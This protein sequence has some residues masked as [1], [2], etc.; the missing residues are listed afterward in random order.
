MLLHKDESLK[1]VPLDWII[2]SLI[3]D[4]LTIEWNDSTWNSIQTILQ[5]TDHP[6]FFC[7]WQMEKKINQF[8]H[9]EFWD[10]LLSGL[11]TC[12]P[13]DTRVTSGPRFC[14]EPNLLRPLI[15][16]ILDF[17]MAPILYW[18]MGPVARPYASHCYSFQVPGFYRRC[19]FVRKK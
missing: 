13:R 10:V 7:L 6:A 17:K 5:R 4:Y 1:I 14:H 16:L 8:F 11:T 19:Q 3:L 15:H 18:V 2:F 12:A 9:L